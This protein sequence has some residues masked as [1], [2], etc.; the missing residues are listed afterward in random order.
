MS[1]TRIALPLSPLTGLISEGFYDVVHELG[2]GFNEPV[3]QKALTI[4][5]RDKGLLVEPNYPL[6]VNFRGQIIGTFQPDL[7]V[8][9][10]VIV[11]IKA[12]SHL[13]GWAQ[14]QLLN[15]LKCAGG[16]VG[17]LVNFGQRPE[18]KRLVMG[19]PTNSLPAL[20]KSNIKGLGRWTGAIDEG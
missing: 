3:C 20:P 12:T 8:E 5:L 17:L 1:S 4:V 9:R 13:E 16:G 2:C 11:E 6:Q 19:D 7:I 15:Y 18:C 14:A 10:L